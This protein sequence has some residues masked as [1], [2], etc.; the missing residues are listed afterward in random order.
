MSSLYLGPNENDINGVTS[1]EFEELGDGEFA[2][3][4]SHTDLNFTREE[5]LKIA[6]W[7][8]NQAVEKDNRYE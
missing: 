7:L 8:L 6:A 4:L 2:L 3:Y 1:A 5:A